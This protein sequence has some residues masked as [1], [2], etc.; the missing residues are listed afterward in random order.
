ME[1]VK[2]PV[3]RKLPIGVYFLL[4]MAIGFSFPLFGI[5]MDTLVQGEPFNL[6]FIFSKWNTR[7]PLIMRASA[8]VGGGVIGFGIASLIR[9]RRIEQE[10]YN[11]SI[12]AY[13]EELE[14]KNNKLSELNEALDGLIY[15]TSHELKTP[16]INLQSLLTMLKSLKDRPDSEAMTDELIVK[17]EAAIGRFKGTITDMMDVSRLE[18]QF[19]LDSESVDLSNCM[20][21]VTDKLA[22]RVDDAQGVLELNIDKAPLIKMPPT[23]LEGILYN[24][25]S[26]ALHFAKPGVP[27]Q[28]GV[29]ARLSGKM[30]CLEISDNGLGIN[31]PDHGDKLFRM[32]TRLHKTSSG[33]GVGLY[34]VKRTVDLAG[35][36]IEVESQL[37]EG[38]LF[39]L[40]LPLAEPDLEV[41]TAIA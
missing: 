16:L 41:Q 28:I 34:A 15:S 13:S 8:V 9:K 27:P 6:D 40:F 2:Q 1:I 5:V 37:G 21:A 19:E 4:G 3:W 33:N 10:K 11:A 20:Q 32:F 18:R 36:R 17:M 22:G 39:R 25:I 24:L 35:G 31:L 14:S 30:I 23:A 26:N 7:L 29:S 12:L 38:T